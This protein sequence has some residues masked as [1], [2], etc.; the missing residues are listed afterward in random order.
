MAPMN[1][2]LQIVKIKHGKGLGNGKGLEMGQCECG[3]KTTHDRRLTSLG[4]VE[5]AKIEVVNE[6]NGN[7]I[8]KV[9]E[10]KVAIDR[11]VAKKIM[12]KP[13]ED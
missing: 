7:L 9:K 12:V 10:S 2:G 11:G 4:F 13:Y 8:V 5:G 3:C 1:E 6:T